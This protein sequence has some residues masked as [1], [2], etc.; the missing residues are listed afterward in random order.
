MGAPYI[1]DISR[2]RVKI[3][4]NR[5]AKNINWHNNKRYNNGQKLKLCLSLTKPHVVQKERLSTG[6]TN[7]FQFPTTAGVSFLAITS[8][9]PPGL[10]HNGYQR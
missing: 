10:Q 8:R 3:S 6:W 1:Y 5:R 7:V 9:G 4:T 2:L